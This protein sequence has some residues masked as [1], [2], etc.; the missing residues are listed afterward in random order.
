MD[1]NGTTL[2]GEAW[3]FVE[4][5]S[6]QCAHLAQSVLDVC[7]L[8]ADMVKTLAMP[9][10]ETRQAGIGSC[11]LKQLQRASVGSA[12]RQKSDTHLLARHL[13]DLAG[14]DAQDVA[15]EQ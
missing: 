12:E 3:L 11:W 8:Q 14:C 6:A 15:V 13:A 1:K 7:H 10:Q 5:G 4:H 2:G 9:L